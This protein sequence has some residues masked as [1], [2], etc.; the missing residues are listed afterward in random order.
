ME[1]NWMEQRW[2]GS[3]E[4]EMEQRPPRGCGAW[5]GVKAARGNGPAF[6]CVRS[7]GPGVVG[8]FW[9]LSELGEGDESH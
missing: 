7:S 2:E 3:E 8:V 1:A 6:S 9:E 5:E 4:A